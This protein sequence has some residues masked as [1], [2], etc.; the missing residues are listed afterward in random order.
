M[1]EIYVDHSATTYVKKEVLEEMLPYFTD[2]FGNASS[3][4]SVGR[5]AKKA[6]DTARKKVA[7][8]INAEADEIYFTASGTEA[9][10]LVLK[11][12]A[13]ANKGKKNHIITSK[14]EHPAVLNTCKSL[15][16]EGYKVT[17][18]NVDKE[19]SIKLEELR[20]SITEDTFLIS[21]MTANNEIGTIQKIE[22]ISKIA[23][24]KGVLFHTDAVQAIGNVDI[25][26]KKLAIDALS[27]SG[28]KFYGPKGVG[29]LYIRKGIDFT[30]I[31]HGG[32]QEKS[33]R[34]GTENV[35]AIVGIGKAIELAKLNIEEYNKKLIELRD[36]T[37]ERL[38]KEIPEVCINGDLNS[39]LPGNVNISIKGVEAQSLL[40]MLDMKGICASS[41][42]AC[43]SGTLSP[44][45][46]LKAIGL[47]DDYAKGTLRIS[48]GDKNTMEDA[49]N[50]VDILKEIVEE[51]RNMK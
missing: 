8:A 48:Y 46:V 39:R 18:L 50:I 23:K 14:I 37:I 20:N 41:G 35:P 12:I 25:D 5:E 17:Y 43:T 10:N 13:H 42:S 9:D 24:F 51:L 30:P 7:Q 31:I 19:G 21:I 44:S 36:Y 11:G 2:K 38:L 16:K 4:Y 45:H 49:K 1:K 29:A 33:K 40:L 27:M 6:V 3:Q 26:V 15:E 34:A 47:S 32:H 22:E 28:H